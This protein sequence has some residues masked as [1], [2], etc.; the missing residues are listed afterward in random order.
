MPS[1]KELSHNLSCFFM[2]I[3]KPLTA[4][5]AGTC[6]KIPKEHCFS[7]VL[8][9]LCIAR[10]KSLIKQVYFL[11]LLIHNRWPNMRNP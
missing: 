9:G 10:R 11:L 8:I 7:V 5:P 2:N 6:E 4:L 3:K 1:F